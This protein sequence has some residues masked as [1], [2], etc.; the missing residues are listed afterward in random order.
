[1]G[2]ERTDLSG[3][4]KPLTNTPFASLGLRVDALQPGPVPESP[5]AAPV[6]PKAGVQ[7][8]VAKTR[9]GG[10]PVFVERRAAG[11]VV[12]VIRNVSGDAEALLS[13]LKKKCG[14]G[15]VVRDGEVEIQGDHRARIEA[16]LQGL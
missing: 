1:M 16:F 6:P 4:G 10:W 15:G 14:A 12:T 11:K 9:K 5:K 7:Y 8:H 13:M 3:D 2:K